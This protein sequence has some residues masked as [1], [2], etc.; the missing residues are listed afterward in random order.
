[1]SAT[2]AAS[3][4][5]QGMN[6]NFKEF[7][8]SNPLDFFPRVRKDDPITSFEAADSIKEVSAKHHKIILECLEKNGPLG[9]DGIARLT[10]L[11]SNQVARRLNELKV[12]CLIVLT[13]NTVKSNSGRNERE[14]TV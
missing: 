7:F 8:S 14:W 9:K 3:T 5:L 11:E 2:D 12:M 6:M 4:H 10:G 1:M 13:G